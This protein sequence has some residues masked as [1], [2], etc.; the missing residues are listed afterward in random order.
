[1]KA[2]AAAKGEKMSAM[3]KISLVTAHHIAEKLSNGFSIRFHEILIMFGAEPSL[4]D[5]CRDD[6]AGDDD[7]D[8]D[9]ILDLGDIT[10]IQA[11]EARYRPERQTRA[12]QQGGV[13]GPLGNIFFRQEEHAKELQED[14]HAEEDGEQP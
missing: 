11:E 2:I 13:D 10:G 4:G 12:H 6:G 8:K 7:P 5:K 9:G 14:L 3:K 1:M